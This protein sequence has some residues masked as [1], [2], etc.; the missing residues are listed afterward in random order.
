MKSVTGNTQKPRKKVMVNCINMD[1]FQCCCLGI[2][3]LRGFSARASDA[4]GVTNTF[5][6][7][8]SCFFMMPWE[9]PFKPCGHYHHTLPL[10][11]NSFEGKWAGSLVKLPNKHPTSPPTPRKTNNHIPQK[12][13]QTQNPSRLSLQYLLS[14]GIWWEE[15]PTWVESS[16]Q[17]T[18]FTCIKSTLL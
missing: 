7:E 15:G 9:L 10:Q 18:Q 14:S 12:N 13:K 4:Q 11:S 3:T 17:C 2:K 16:S 8:T 1:I 6:V 5:P